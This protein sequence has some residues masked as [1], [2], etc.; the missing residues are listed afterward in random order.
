MLVLTRKAD[1][2][3]VIPELG[4]TITVLA[5]GP[6]RVRIGIEAPREITIRRS[7]LGEVP[8]KV[9]RRADACPLEVAHPVAST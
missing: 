9:L 4:I 2:S 3:I 6:N 5:V 8:N 7:E 1:E